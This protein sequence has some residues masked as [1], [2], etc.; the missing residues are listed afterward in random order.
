MIMLGLIKR[1]E[2]ADLGHAQGFDGRPQMH[3]AHAQCHMHRPGVGADQVLSCSLQ[4]SLGRRGHFLLRAIVD[5]Q[6]EFGARNP[7]HQIPVAQA[8]GNA[9]GNLTDHLIGH[10]EPIGLVDHPEIV[11]MGNQIT[12][13]QR[14]VVPPV[15]HLLQLVKKGTAILQAGQVIE[16]AEKTLALFPV[17]PIIDD[18]HH[19][20]YPLGAPVAAREPAANFLDPEPRICGKPVRRKAIDALIA[21]A[22]TIIRA[23]GCKYG[24]IASTFRVGSDVIGKG[25]TGGKICHHI[26]LHHI[27]RVGAP[28][29]LV[30]TRLP[31]IDHFANACQ[32]VPY[33]RGIALFALLLQSR[34]SFFTCL[35]T[36]DL[37]FNCP[38]RIRVTHPD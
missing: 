19:T 32:N 18:P 10:I 15:Q 33:F 28:A 31:I 6:P 2:G 36:S 16:L 11:D 9:A 4:E 35:P 23:A 3:P 20:L 12:G 24:A 26:R 29:E 27:K 22:R 37:P 7:T 8:M 1:I 21:H 38:T 25:I 30:A 5:Q 14:A 13:R 17:L 34:R